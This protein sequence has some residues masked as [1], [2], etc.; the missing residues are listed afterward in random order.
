MPV[1]GMI[2]MTPT[3]LVEETARW[4][5]RLEPADRESRLG[6]RRGGSRERI[7][8]AVSAR[9]GTDIAA[10][11]LARGDRLGLGRRGRVIVGVVGLV[12]VLMAGFDV[13]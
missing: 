8:S 7:R 2:C 5:A 4:Y 9:L 3:A 1:T 10:S 11:G 6:R 13:G 12:A